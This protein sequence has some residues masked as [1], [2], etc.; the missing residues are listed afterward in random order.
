M[1]VLETTRANTLSRR[2]MLRVA[3]LPIEAVQ[4]LRSPRLHQR[5]EELLTEEQR[6]SSAGAELSDRLGALVSQFE[7]DQLR[8]SVLSLR[9]QV[10][11]NRLPSGLPAAWTSRGGS[12]ARPARR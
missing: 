4:R 10:F 12:V 11:N 8:R 7:D 1:T 3:G 2:F 6:L 5:A 9:R